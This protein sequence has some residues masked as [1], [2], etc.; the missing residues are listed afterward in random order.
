MNPKKFTCFFLKMIAQKKGFLFAL[1]LM[2][3]S[4][5]NAQDK[6][7]HFEHGSK[8]KSIL[9]TAKKENKYIFVDCF[10]TWCGPCK[11]MSAN[12]FPKEEVGTFFN[13]NF[14][15][16]KFQIDS[17][18]KDE[19]EI[20]N[21]YADASFIAKAYNIRAYPTY[22]FFN[23]DG[24][25]VHQ[26]L[27]SSEAD[28]FIAKG[29][30]AMNP[31]KQYFTQVKKYDAGNREPL[32]LKNLAMVSRGAFDQ[33]GTSKYAS[34]YLATKP[35]LENKETLRFIY[36]TT[37]SSRDEGFSIMLSNPA[38]FETVV[39]RH[40]LHGALSGLISKDEAEKIDYGF[41]KFDTKQWETYSAVLTKKYPEYADEVLVGF[42]TS[43]FRN[44]KDW[45]SYASA[46]N[47]YASSKY[48][49]N[50]EL[51]DFAWT[52]FKNCNDKKLLTAAAGWSKKFFEKE[53]KQNATYMDTYANLL[54]KL[55]QKENAIIWEQKAMTADIAQGHDTIWEEEVIGKI[56]KGVPTW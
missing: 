30:N 12:I 35:D 51:N 20:K 22:L 18:T 7:I 47:Q 50:A 24:E 36:E 13:N 34:A 33:A 23:S 17:T 53:T 10:T 52:I 27:G 19:E 16:A 9:E 4:G 8:W 26:E 49:N 44:K 15:S 43:I 5:A 54:Y 28:E 38:K 42:K 1:L 32:F 55:G 56:K 21:Q 11:Y 6:G 48:I 31:G 29:A 25:L 39:D 40:E 41:Q 45:K 2:I 3:I 14:I 37:M 46:I